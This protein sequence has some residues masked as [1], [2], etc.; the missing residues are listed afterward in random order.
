[1]ESIPPPQQ[2][3]PSYPPNTASVPGLIRG[4]VEGLQVR[5]EPSQWQY[6]SVT[7]WD[8][9]LERHDTEGNPMSRVQVE[10]R[11]WSFV[12]SINN[13]DWIEI[14]DEWQEGEIVRPHQVHNLS[15]STMVTAKGPSSI[16][17]IAIIAFIV[18]WLAVAVFI[19]STA[20]SHHLF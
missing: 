3:K 11:G 15:T 8:F 19:V 4:M 6:P 13:G 10:M 7:I 16:K 2:P 17:K 5:M 9:R 1:M 20:L 12:G 18:F 14:K